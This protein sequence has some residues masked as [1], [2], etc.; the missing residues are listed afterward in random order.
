MAFALF[1]IGYLTA[2]QFDLGVR[3]VATF[4]LQC[5]AVYV[6]FARSAAAQRHLCRGIFPQPFLHVG[7]RAERHYMPTHRQTL[8]E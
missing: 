4:F 6:C 8:S 3:P 5:R 2:F 1:V 7:V